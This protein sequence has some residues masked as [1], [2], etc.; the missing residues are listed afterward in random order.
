MANEFSIE[1]IQGILGT[2]QEQTTGR[3]VTPG[4]RTIGGEQPQDIQTLGGS[5]AAEMQLQSQETSLERELNLLILSKDPN[6]TEA[7]ALNNYSRQ[8]IE[9]ILDEATFSPDLLEERATRRTQDLE[10]KLSDVAQNLQKA[11][12]G[13]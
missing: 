13:E 7:Q 9:A 1:R 8:Q 11:K 3:P 12:K 4:V 10:T 2:Q 6:A 5:D